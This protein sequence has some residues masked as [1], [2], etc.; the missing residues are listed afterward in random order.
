VGDLGI[1][2]ANWSDNVYELPAAVPE[3]TTMALLALGGAVLIR[4]RR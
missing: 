1:L 2:A 3:P 4:R